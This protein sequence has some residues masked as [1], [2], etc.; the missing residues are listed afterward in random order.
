MHRSY[1]FDISQHLNDQPLD[2][3]SGHVARGAAPHSGFG[4]VLAILSRFLIGDQCFEPPTTSRTLR[5]V[6]VEREIIVPAELAE[7]HENTWARRV[8]CGSLDCPQWLLRL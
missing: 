2:L 6:S 8:G 7:L 4:R 5:V 1:C 3:C